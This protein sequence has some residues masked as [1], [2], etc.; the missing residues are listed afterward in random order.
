MF[1]LMSEKKISIGR[2]HA[3]VCLPN[4]RFTPTICN[5]WDHI[6]SYKSQD[7]FSGINTEREEKPHTELCRTSTGDNTY[8]SPQTLLSM[9]ERKASQG[10]RIHH[11]LSEK[12]DRIDSLNTQIIDEV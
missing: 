8:S 5:I 9:H 7:A 11:T 6:P 2:K 10:V 12:D 4:S 1:E 3:K